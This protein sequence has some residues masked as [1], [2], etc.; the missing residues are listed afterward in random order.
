MG[1]EPFRRLEI[2]Q[3]LEDAEPAE[4]A[5]MREVDA[6]RACSGVSK[7]KNKWL[8]SRWD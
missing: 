2:E 8:M 1:K 4:V 5:A 7:R 3:E 6:R